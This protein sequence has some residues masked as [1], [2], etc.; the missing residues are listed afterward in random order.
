MTVPDT[1][2]DVERAVRALTRAEV[3]SLGIE[4]TLPVIYPSGRNVVVVVEPGETESLLHDSGFGSMCLLEEGIQLNNQLRRRLGRLARN[5]GCAFAD[6]R[7][8][9]VVE[10]EHLAVGV[11]LVANASRSV[12]DV[13]LEARRHIERQ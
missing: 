3:T 11:A 12:G 13:A 2:L 1:L 7:V 8:S 9:R 10:N 6:G 4:V 5:Y